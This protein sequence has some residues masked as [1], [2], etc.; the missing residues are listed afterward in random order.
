MTHNGPFCI[1]GQKL[2]RTTGFAFPT[3]EA[4]LNERLISILRGQITGQN[5]TSHIAI[6]R[7]K[8]APSAEVRRGMGYSLSDF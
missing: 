6:W 5:S 8:S 7:F 1:V 2:E 4:R 3:T